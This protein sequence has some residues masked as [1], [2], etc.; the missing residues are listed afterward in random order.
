MFDNER[1][2]N[3]FLMGYAKMLVADIPDERLTEQPVPGVNHPAWILGHLT[4]A[5]DFAVGLLGSQNAQ[6][7]SWA[8]LFGGG[9][10]PSSVRSEY[11]DKE[12]LMT[13]LERS[14]ARVREL[15][16]GASQQSLG[17][18]N[19]H[20]LLKDRLKTVGVQLSFLLTG[21]FAVHLGQLS[22]WRRLIGTPPMF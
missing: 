9:S 14:Y 20:P 17:Q 15:A 3:E 19:T 8:K 10:I 1:Q 6:P 18:P 13:A 5:S 4:L 16:A 11:P 12:E 22:M 2:I 7:E 21:H